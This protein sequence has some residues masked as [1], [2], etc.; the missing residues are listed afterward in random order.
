HGSR[1]LRHHAPAI[2]AKAQ[3]YR[4]HAPEWRGQHARQGGEGGLVRA[5][6]RH[7]AEIVIRSVT[8]L[9]DHLGV[10]VARTRQRAEYVRDVRGL[11]SR[12]DARLF[13]FQALARPATGPAELVEPQGRAVPVGELDLAYGA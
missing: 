5:V 4:A 10:D 12:R 9:E 1:A 6:R 2:T 7:D 11:R 3:R 13:L 8:Q